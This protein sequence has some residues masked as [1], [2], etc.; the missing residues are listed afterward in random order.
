M[1]I[2]TDHK[3]YLSNA[4]MRLL[5]RECGFEHIRSQFNPFKGNILT[6]FKANHG[7]D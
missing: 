3:V 6:A 1:N 7:A 4:T 5:P 2:S